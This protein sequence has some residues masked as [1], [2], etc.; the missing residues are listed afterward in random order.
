MVFGLFEDKKISMTLDKTAY[1]PGETISGK[2]KLELKK[3]APAEKLSVRLVY[4]VPNE[5]YTK[6]AEKEFAAIVL[7]PS[8]EYQTSE[9]TFSIK[10][11]EKPPSVDFPPKSDPSMAEAWKRDDALGLNCFSVVG[12]LDIRGQKGLTK[13]EYIKIKY[14]AY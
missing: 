2:L 10:I 5:D 13:Q 3:P 12:Q 9:L 7:G 6:P 4:F 8:R 11:P 14:Y 1:S